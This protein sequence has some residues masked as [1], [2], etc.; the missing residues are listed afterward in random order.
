VNL[1]VQSDTIVER[2]VLAADMLIE[3][4]ESTGKNTDIVLVR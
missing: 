1:K 2:V 3:F 4:D